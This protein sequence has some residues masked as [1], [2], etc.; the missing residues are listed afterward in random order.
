MNEAF[1]AMLTDGLIEDRGENETESSFY[2]TEKGLQAQPSVEHPDPDVIRQ[3]ISKAV[4]FIEVEDLY[5]LRGDLMRELMTLRN[6]ASASRERYSMFNFE[7]S[8]L[9]QEM[10][11]Q[12][13]F[14]REELKKQ[15]VEGRFEPVRWGLHD[16]QQSPEK[17]FEPVKSGKST[18]NRSL[19]STSIPI[20]NRFS[21]LSYETEENQSSNNNNNDEFQTTSQ[22]KERQ[23][24]VIAQSVTSN[25]GSD[26]Q[27]TNSIINTGKSSN[28]SD[29]GKPKVT[30]LGDSIVKHVKGRKIPHSLKNQQRITVK[31]FPGATTQDYAIPTKKRKPGMIILHVGTNDLKS[32]QTPCEIA[33]KIDKLA[34]DLNLWQEMTRRKRMI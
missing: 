15:R 13:K 32:G 4:N 24:S 17:S 23:R 10:K 6:E 12:L 7:D 25:K 5:T 20:Q 1:D 18:R 14:L 27:Q 28:N 9:F 16:K 22:N 21:A 26:K 33:G 30:I 19:P 34:K 29:K 3:E 31:S 8:I 11:E 2:M